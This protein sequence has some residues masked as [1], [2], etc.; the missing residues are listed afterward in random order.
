MLE[1]EVKILD[2]D[3]DK[4]RELLDKHAL[5][6]FRKTLVRE[7]HFEHSGIEMRGVAVFRL[8][9]VGKMPELGV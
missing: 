5:N 6:L 4:A 7:L 9:Q 3:V 8:R 2:I 1:T